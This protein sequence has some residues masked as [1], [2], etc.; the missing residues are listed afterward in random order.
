MQ[1]ACREAVRVLKPGGTARIMLY[2]R[3]SYHYGLV[4]YLV[5][6]LVWALLQLP[7][8]LGGAIAHFLPRKFRE[9][10]E[11]CVEDGFGL[12]RILSISTD[13]STAGEANYNPLSYF[14]TRDEVR[15][16]FAGLEEFDFYTTDLKYFP[17]PFLRRAVEDRWGFFLQITAKKPTRAD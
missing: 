3:D 1:G 4:R 16:L 13:T 10:Y 5:T 15:G 12:D 11:I 2:H 14:V 17:L 9:T 6:P 8:G 7:F